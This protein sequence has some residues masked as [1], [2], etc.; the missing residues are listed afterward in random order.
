MKQR[1]YKH[2]AWDYGIDL[3]KWEKRIKDFCKTKGLYFVCAIGLLGLSILFTGSLLCFA[4][5]YPLTTLLYLLIVLL[6]VMTI[7]KYYRDGYL[8]ER[9]IHG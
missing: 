3:N 4:I 7:F 1:I 5:V 9:R 8:F 2:I 6:A